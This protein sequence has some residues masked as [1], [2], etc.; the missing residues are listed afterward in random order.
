MGSL[1]HKFYLFRQ[2][3]QDEYVAYMRGVV[4]TPVAEHAL[5]DVKKLTSI[6][7]AASHVLQL[8]DPD[9][10]AE[11]LGFAFRGSVQAYDAIIL[12]TPLIFEENFLLPSDMLDD[13]GKNYFCE[14]GYRYQF[15][16]PSPGNRRNRRMF[17]TC[18]YGLAS[19]RKEK[20]GLNVVIEPHISLPKEFIN[21]VVDSEYGERLL[22]AFVDLSFF[23]NHDW[24]HSI[25]I[26][27]INRDVTGIPEFLPARRNRYASRVAENFLKPGEQ[28]IPT[29]GYE[30]FHLR[31]QADLLQDMC[32][33]E[34]NPFVDALDAYLS[35]WKDFHVEMSMRACMDDP[36]LTPAAYAI[37]LLAFNL[38]R[39]LP[40]E[41]PVVQTILDDPDAGRYRDVIEDMYTVKTT[42]VFF[43]TGQ[44]KKRK[45]DPL[46]K[47]CILPKDEF[48][49][50]SPY[51]IGRIWP[52]SKLFYK[53][54]TSDDYSEQV[55]SIACHGVAAA[56]A[57]FD[58]IIPY[59]GTIKSHMTLDV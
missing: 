2:G 14:K 25:F 33:E 32:K 52:F 51:S 30:N 3:Q 23:T 7:N 19:V 53:T 1:D 16:E 36:A 46:V 39:A 54:Y 48:L 28:L 58:D 40:F 41:H 50:E 31:F 13:S 10:T 27:S 26:D 55:R 59:K 29:S 24:L 21:V 45:K 20:G 56:M 35:A 42:G 49:V 9:L 17:D 47:E 38:V 8:S 44:P 22:G 18:G 5:A 34:V 43:G 12:N 6:F 11:R 37:K 15:V 4:E 57:D